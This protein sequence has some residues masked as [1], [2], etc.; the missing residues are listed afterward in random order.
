MAGQERRAASAAGVAYVGLGDVPAHA[1]Q[2]RAEATVGDAR[3]SLDLRDGNAVGA[4][5]FHIEEPSVIRVPND[6]PCG[7]AISAAGGL[8]IGVEKGTDGWEFR[9]DPVSQSM[10]QHNGMRAITEHLTRALARAS[11]IGTT[12][13]AIVIDIDG[14]EGVLDK[15]GPQAA[16]DVI[17]SVAGRLQQACRPSDAVV[18]IG[19]S[20][21]AIACEDVRGARDAGAIAQRLSRTL[22]GIIV[23]GPHRIEL[24]LRVNVGVALAAGSRLRPTDLLDEAEIARGRSADA[25]TRFEIFDAE[26]SSDAVRRLQL[27]SEFRRGLPAGQLELYFQ[28]ILNLRSGTVDAAEALVRWNHPHAG[29]LRPSEFLHIADQIDLVA[30]LAKWT[31]RSALAELAR[32]DEV[33]N[34]T[35]S[36]AVH[37]NVSPNQLMDQRVGRTVEEALTDYGIAP[38]RLVLEITESA[39]VEDGGIVER[40]IGHLRDMGVRFA[41]DDFGTG[42]SSLSYLGRIPADILK[43]DKTFIEGVGG[44]AADTLV[45]AS[46]IS[47]ARAHGLTAVAEGIETMEQLDRLR[48]LDCDAVQ[49]FL[50]APPLPAA[51]ALEAVRRPFQTS[52]A[53]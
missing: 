30:Q 24:A 36:V 41:I 14:Y 13:A 34:L 5:V 43:I 47:L 51:I 44:S 52:A 49:G 39:F 27:E 46:L 25:G 1:S 3:A 15:L 33:A 8:E 48:H 45:A 18:R 7:F 12:V 2:D 10:P 19:V 31:V 35:N 50:V 22:D 23:A 11:R 53:S 4:Q 40:S 6:H 38:H 17:G 16:A 21:F 42:F 28:P 26:A 32:W 20:T 29:L 37:I 9:V